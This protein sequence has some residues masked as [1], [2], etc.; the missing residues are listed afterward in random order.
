MAARLTLPPSGGS[1]PGPSLFGTTSSGAASVGFIVPK[2]VRLVGVLFGGFSAA[3]VKLDGPGGTILED[4][5]VGT[6][7]P[8]TWGTPGLMMAAGDW[9]LT[10]KDGTS[11][12]SFNFN[13]LLSEET[14]PET[15]R[16]LCP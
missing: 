16:L 13:L 5:R 8:W 14:W 6:G 3:T 12:A 4:V 9:T 1:G 7:I 2:A 10:I 11:D 15:S